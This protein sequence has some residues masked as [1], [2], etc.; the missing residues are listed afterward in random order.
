MQIKGTLIKAL[1]LQTGTGQNGVWKKKQYIIET[2]GDY[3]KKICVTAWNKA[4]AN[5][6]INLNSE[7]TIDLDIE[8]KEYNGKWYT[9]IK[10]WK[11][12]GKSQP[13][14]SQESEVEDI[15]PF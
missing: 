15:L 9:D 8:S 14:A 3:P 4:I 5:M 7:V 6:D 1:E 13:E 11:V 2:K 12:D 10:V